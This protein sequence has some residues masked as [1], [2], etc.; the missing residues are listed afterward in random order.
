MGKGCRPRPFSVT[1]D[2][3]A[4]RFDAIFGKR[5]PKSQDLKQEL[6]VAEQQETVADHSSSL[7]SIK[8]FKGSIQHK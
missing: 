6:D 3:Y 1:A 5:M 7:N 4:S 8:S 2:E